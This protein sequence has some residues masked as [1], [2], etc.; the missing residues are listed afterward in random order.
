MPS[1]KMKYHAKGKELK[2]AIR[3]SVSDVVHPYTWLVVRVGTC[4]IRSRTTARQHFLAW[5][6]H[7]NLCNRLQSQ[8]AIYQN[9]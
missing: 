6:S 4:K 5:K 1:D 7:Q 3:L 9:H 8:Q 2:G